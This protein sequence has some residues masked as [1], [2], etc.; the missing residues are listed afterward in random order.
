M[1]LTICLTDIRLISWEVRNENETP[2]TVEGN[3]CAIF[4]INTQACSGLSH[5]SRI[6][7]VKDQSSRQLPQSSRVQ[8]FFHHMTVAAL[9]HDIL[10]Q[11][12]IELK[13]YTWLDILGVVTTE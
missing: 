4:M 6:L 3:E 8:L 12:D 10:A 2:A 9:P 7:V 13:V 11:K 5:E 1:G